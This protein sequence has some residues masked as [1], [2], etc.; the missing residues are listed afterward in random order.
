[1]PL[2]S[3]LVILLFLIK[4]FDIFSKYRLLPPLLLKVLSVI[5]ILYADTSIESP[6][7]VL[8]AIVLLIILIFV[9][10]LPFNPSSLEFVILLS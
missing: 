6:F 9:T 5:V 1:M 4:D 8:F 10:I 7:P 3:P 2:L